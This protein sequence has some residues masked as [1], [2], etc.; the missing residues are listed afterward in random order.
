MRFAHRVTTPAA[1]SEVWA[2]L[3]DVERWPEW[4]PWVRRVEARGR[5][6]EGQHLMVL[7]R[8][9]PLRVPVDVR[10]VA[11]SRGLGVTVHTAPGWR[12]HVDHSVQPGEGGGSVVRVTTVLEGPLARVV[13][14]PLWL[15]SGITTRM[16]G[17]RATR[18]H[19]RAAGSAE[20]GAA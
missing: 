18:E 13:A 11:P 16:L 6:R 17:R 12:E 15:G 3:E 2:V 19:Q 8:W 20:V 10:L 9:V 5:V 1:P 7:A 4:D 14:L